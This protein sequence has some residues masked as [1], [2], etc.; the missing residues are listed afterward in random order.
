MLDASTAF[1]RK[2]QGIGLIH[3]C[4]GTTSHLDFIS[5]GVMVSVY[6]HTPQLLP[7]GAAWSRKPGSSRTFFLAANISIGPNA[8]CFHLNTEPGQAKNE[9]IEKR[10][11]VHCAIRQTLLRAWYSS[12]SCLALPP[13]PSRPCEIRHGAHQLHLFQGTINRERRFRR[14]R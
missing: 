8:P 12:V 13:G 1:T 11:Q 6:T 7:L 9:N 3:Q 4:E 2:I 5:C 14:G 10:K